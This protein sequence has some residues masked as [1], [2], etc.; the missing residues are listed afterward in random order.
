[1]SNEIEHATMRDVARVAGVSLAT[2]SYVVN[3]GPRPVSTRS[4]RQVLAAIEQLGYEARRK[5]S[6]EVT[7]GLIVPHATHAFFGR[8]V[9]RVEA[10]GGP[11][12]DLVDRFRRA[13]SGP[14]TGA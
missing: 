11:H 1:M 3:G 12:G 9:A 6:A 5:R 8:V 7:L 2:V 4:R 14:Q 13:E 10:A